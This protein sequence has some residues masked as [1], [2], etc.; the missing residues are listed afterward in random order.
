MPMAVPDFLH[1][2]I[3]LAQSLA[4]LH[5]VR[6]VHR[7]INSTNIVWDTS[8]GRATLNDFG[9]ATTLSALTVTSTGLNQLEGTLAYV[10]PEQTGR[11]GTFG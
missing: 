6:V 4:G 11:P 8:S 2:A 7:D 9:I 10:S 5:R 1:I 3:Q